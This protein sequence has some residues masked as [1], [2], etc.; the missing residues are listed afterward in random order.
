[1]G[2]VENHIEKVMH[3]ENRIVVTFANYHTCCWT[4]SL[5][6]KTGKIDLG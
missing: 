3:T 2:E 1:M 6:V 5:E 4:G